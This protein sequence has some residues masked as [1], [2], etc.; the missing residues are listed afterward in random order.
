LLVA[1]AN[2]N[3][4]LEYDS[5]SGA[6]VGTGI[7][8]DNAGPIGLAFG[9][10]GNL[11]ASSNTGPQQVLEF[12]GT[13]GAQVGT[14]IFVPPGSAGMGLPYGLVFGPNGN[15][16]VADRFHHQVLEFNGASGAPVGNGVFVAPGT[17]G[18]SAPYGLAFGPN[19]NLFVSDVNDNGGTGQILEFDGT[20]GAP[21]GRQ[22][23]HQSNPGIQWH[24][25]GPRRQRGLC[26]RR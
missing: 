22:R 2:S 14:G 21:V 25:G 1:S 24:D 7:F 26:H 11:F 8:A 10:N 20:T 13:T 4:V 15:L 23:R 17:A 6:P 3:Q 18:L 5:A 9:P 16:F 19:G 12:D